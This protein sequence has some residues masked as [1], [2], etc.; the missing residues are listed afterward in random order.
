MDEP[1]T[2]DERVPGEA[3]EDTGAG[4]AADD[5]AARLE[6]LQTDL[7]QGLVV[8]GQRLTRLEKH[9]ETKILYDRAKDETIDALHRELQDYR[10]GLQFQHLRPLVADVLTVYDDLGDVLERFAVESPEALLEPVA[11]LLKQLIALRDD[12]G[13]ALEKQGFELYE[14]PGEAVD[15]AFQRVQ[16]VITTT[17]PARDRTI[18]RRVRR[19]LRYGERVIRPE[20]IEAYR[21]EPGR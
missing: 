12:L 5:L 10:D 13:S 2:D 9:F 14:H 6:A 21:Y 1:Y 18:A 11:S 8:L 19:G 4:V 20:I 3:A 7:R 15:R 16:A 17:D